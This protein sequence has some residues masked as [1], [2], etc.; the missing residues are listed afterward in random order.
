M[1]ALKNNFIP[2][3][4]GEPKAIFQAP[5]SGDRVVTIE[6][7]NSN[8]TSARIDIQL[9]D[10]TGKIIKSFPQSV[11][12]GA[13]ETFR[14]HNIP[15]LAGKRLVVSSNQPN[16]AARCYLPTF[17]VQPG[18]AEIARG[19]SEEITVYFMGEGSQTVV[20]NSAIE[21][22]TINPA[23]APVTRTTPAVFTVT[24][25][26]AHYNEGLVDFVI[27]ALKLKTFVAINR[28][29]VNDPLVTP[30]PEPSDTSEIDMLGAY[31]TSRDTVSA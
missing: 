21:G 25:D 8:S 15:V 19:A 31:L 5:E 27:E 22:V 30:D 4:I 20:G 24:R 10:N 1:P 12:I 2:L 29:T 14:K 16:I 7:I 18:Q 26:T 17:F 9:M 28:D 23:S 6:F 3:F 11:N 13:R